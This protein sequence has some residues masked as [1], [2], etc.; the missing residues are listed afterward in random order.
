MNS[1]QSG[2]TNSS[3]CN[4]KHLNFC[5]SSL[6]DANDLLGT[7]GYMLHPEPRQPSV[8]LLLHHRFWDNSVWP[9]NKEGH[10]P[11]F[12]WHPWYHPNMTN[13]VRVALFVHWYVDSLVL[14][15]CF[16]ISKGGET[17][18]RFLCWDL[19]L[20]IPFYRSTSF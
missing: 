19:S 4:C 17:K 3:E 18:I 20:V 9:T 1:R 13:L 11:F 16:F 15:T 2:C 12:T 7:L 6:H 8:C 10:M 5:H 14:M